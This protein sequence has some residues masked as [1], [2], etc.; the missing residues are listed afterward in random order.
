M[1]DAMIDKITVRVT[2]A[3]RK[4]IESHAAK[5]RLKT[6]EFIRQKLLSTPNDSFVDKVNFY[7]NINHYLTE[8]TK[9]NLI[10]NQMLYQLM[11]NAFGE[12]EAEAICE[13]ISQQMEKLTNNEEENKNAQI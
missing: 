2:A 6:S 9:R 10:L 12:N 1:N 11:V 4:K 3:E 13:Q 5:N 7:Q 8:I